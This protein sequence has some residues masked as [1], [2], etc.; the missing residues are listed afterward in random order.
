[1]C[2]AHST[3][4]ADFTAMKRNSIIRKANCWLFGLFTRQLV[5]Y[6]GFGRL[7]ICGSLFNTC[8]NMAATGE[9]REGETSPQPHRRIHKGTSEQARCILGTCLGVDTGNIS[10]VERR[11][12]S[13]K[14][15]KTVEGEYVRDRSEC[16][17]LWWKKGFH[18]GRRGASTH[19]K[20]IR[21]PALLQE[22][23]VPLRRWINAVLS[24]AEM[25]FF[26]HAQS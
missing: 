15:G 4:A 26:F 16:P 7:W 2:A 22:A 18:T 25:D 13:I 6:F 19:T 9:L 10:R 12:I 24:R 14:F 8:T 17:R 1:M 20:P 21:F 3:A 5:Y 11:M 23:G